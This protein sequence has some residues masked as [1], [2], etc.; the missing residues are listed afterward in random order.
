MTDRVR[1]RL[2]VI[3]AA[4]PFLNTAAVR[5]GEFTDGYLQLKEDAR[6]AKTRAW[7][8]YLTEPLGRP[9]CGA[10]AAIEEMKYH[11]T[12]AGVTFA[13]KRVKGKGVVHLVRRI[14]AK[15]EKGAGSS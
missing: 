7:A 6:C 13:L 3:L 15:E 10:R 12:A 2:L 4:A 9:I 8:R 14:G 11:A 5:A 1:L